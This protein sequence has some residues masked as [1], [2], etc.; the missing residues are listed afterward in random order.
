MFSIN[1][2]SIKVIDTKIFSKLFI[3]LVLVVFISFIFIRQ[4][5]VNAL[6]VDRH[7]ISGIH[8][9]LLVGLSTL[10][11]L[12]AS[13]RGGLRYPYHIIFFFILWTSVSFNLIVNISSL[14]IPQLVVGVFY[15]YFG[16]LFFYT[17]LAYGRCL[18]E[19]ISTLSKIFVGLFLISFFV[20][21]QQFYKIEPFFLFQTDNSVITKETF[22][23][24]TRVNGLYGNFV[25]Y[26]YIAYIA[27][28]YF[29]FKSLELRSFSYAMLTFLSMASIL[30]TSTRA[31]IFFIFITFFILLIFNLKKNLYKVLYFLFGFLPILFLLFLLIEPEIIEP[32]L[33]VLLSRDK[34]TQVSNDVRIEQFMSAITWIEEYFYYGLGPG[35]LLGPNEFK[36]QFVTDGIVFMY[37]MELGTI[38]LLILLTL[39]TIFFVRIFIASIIHFHGS[40]LAKMTFFLILVNV[41]Y[42]PINS[43][44]ALPSSFVLTLTIIGSFYFK[45]IR[46]E[47]AY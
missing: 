27:F 39:L 12:K 7:A 37:L 22:Y 31:Y 21:L 18:E 23:G 40:I 28:I 14:S 20:S 30:M 33:N 11:L 41:V 1:V 9:L 24:T 32:L 3:G 6:G 17:Y 5:Y 10:I 35:F 47:K 36:K 44:I 25:D 2:C 13:Y 15:Y 19:N 8:V 26:A 4:V 46:R 29:L 42:S 38:S 16:V 43:A 45:E 34:H